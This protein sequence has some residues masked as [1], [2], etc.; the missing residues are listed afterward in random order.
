MAGAGARAAQGRLSPARQAGPGLGRPRSLRSPPQS[1]T[2]RSK[3]L[4]GAR[5]TSWPTP[6]RVPMDQPNLYPV[7][8]YVYDL[9]KGLAR[10]LSPIML[11]EG[12]GAGGKAGQNGA[13][14]CQDGRPRWGGLDLGSQGDAGSRVEESPVTEGRDLRFGPLAPL[15]CLHV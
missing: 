15:S 10:R 12:A 5:R 4:P 14:R 3:P 11:G 9:S 7:K 6:P 2:G 8:L 1:D 13:R